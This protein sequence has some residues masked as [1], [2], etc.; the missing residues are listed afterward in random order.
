MLNDLFAFF[1]FSESEP[2]EQLIKKANKIRR[3]LSLR[4]RRFTNMKDKLDVSISVS[5]TDRREHIFQKSR[6]LET[7]LS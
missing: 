6:Q 7:F 5:Q 1:V 4:E 3:K 2:Q